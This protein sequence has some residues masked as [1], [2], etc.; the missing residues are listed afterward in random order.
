MASHAGGYD[1]IYEVRGPAAW[2]TINRPEKYN[3]FRG[4]T[5]EELIHA[6][7]KA[8]FSAASLHTAPLQP[9][10]RVTGVS[11]EAT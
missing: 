5:C 9:K 10:R 8:G 4:Q 2:I 3:A 11:L 7:N 1:I 6:I